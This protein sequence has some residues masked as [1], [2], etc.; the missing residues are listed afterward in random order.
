MMID[1]NCDLG[2]GFG[3]YTIGDDPQMLTIVSSANIACGFHAGDPRVMHQTLKLAEAN[4]VQAG[5]HPGFF[6][7]FGF[8]RR[9]IRGDSLEEIEWQIIYQIGAL[10]GLA[11]SLGCRV[12][13]VKAHGSL[14]NMA[15]EDP[16]LALAVARAIKAADPELIFVVMPG[17]ETERAGQRLDLCLAREIYADRAYAESGNLLP[18]KLDGA[19]IHDPIVARNRVLE[20]VRERAIV[21][22]SGTR[23]PARIDSVCVHGDTP[24]A[25]AMAREVRRGLE[26]HNFAIRPMS[27]VVARC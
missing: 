21:T 3:A 12:R 10:Q 4:G 18:R 25:V 16:E 6:D 17:L 8:G 15:A 14:G 1:L 2:E 22:A 20:M 7:L 13:H 26:E 24:G 9:Q 5:A 11:K 23:L 19:V 27:E